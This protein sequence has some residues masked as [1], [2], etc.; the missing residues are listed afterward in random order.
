MC[1][2]ERCEI[3]LSHFFLHLP[4]IS[5]LNYYF[6][7]KFPILLICKNHF[8][9]S[10]ISSICMSYAIKTGCSLFAQ[11]NQ[12]AMNRGVLTLTWYTYMCLP[13][14][15]LFCKIWYNNQWDFIRDQGALITKIGCILSNYGKKHL[16]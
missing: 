10:N 1:K 7:N 9:F 12:I 2:P 4:D 6:F 3:V 8:T 16:T 14:E 11:K 13:F 15:V 5:C